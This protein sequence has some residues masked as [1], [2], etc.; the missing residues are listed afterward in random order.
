MVNQFVVLDEINWLHDHQLD[1]KLINMLLEF[2]IELERSDEI[3]QKVLQN[4]IKVHENL[5]NVIN[6]LDLDF[7]STKIKKLISEETNK[8]TEEYKTLIFD[9]LNFVNSTREL[10]IIF[11]G[12]IKDEMV[13][14]LSLIGWPNLT[15]K[16]ISL[17]LWTMETHIILTKMVNIMIFTLKI[18]ME[19]NISL[20]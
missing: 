10:K 14:F 3:K 13:N 6:A 17:S 12:L 11:S 15:M 16:K 9:F 4:S 5:H 7:F 8:D 1:G 18:W 2:L 19:L 20:K